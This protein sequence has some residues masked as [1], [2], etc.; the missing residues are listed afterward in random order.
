[1]VCEKK[2]NTSHVHHPPPPVESREICDGSRGIDVD[3]RIKAMLLRKVQLPSFPGG[4]FDAGQLHGV[5]TTEREFPPN[6]ALP[7][8]LP[9]KRDGSRCGAPLARDHEP[10]T[11]IA[12]SSGLDC[13]D[14]NPYAQLYHGTYHSIQLH[15]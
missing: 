8:T 13:Y 14:E 5:E 1:M 12:P 6:V 3:A 7:P 10:A 2:E 9:A 15:H 4:T 11:K